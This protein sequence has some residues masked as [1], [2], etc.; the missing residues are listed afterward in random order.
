MNSGLAIA[1][2]TAVLKNLLEDGLVQNTALSSMGNI[3]VTTLPPDQISVGVDGQPQLNLFLYQVSQ[4]RNAD[5]I[6]HGAQE[7]NPDNFSRSAQANPLNETSRLAINLHY[8]ITVY[9]T[10]DFQTE[11]L[12]GCVMQLMHQSP[13]LSNDAIRSSLKHAA[14]MNRAGPFAQAVASNSFDVL[15]NQLGQV[16]IEPD[17]FD[18]EQ[19]S[20]LWSLLQ[21]SY[22]PS[23]TYQVSMVSISSEKSSNPM[24]MD[25]REEASNDREV[26]VIEKVIASPATN[27]AITPGCDL[28]LYGKHLDGD[29]TKVRLD[30]DELTPT[31][32]EDIR[33]LVKSSPT[34]QAGVH[35]I[36]VI[37]K[38]VTDPL[39]A[40]GISSN[41]ATFILRPRITASA[42]IP[43]SD[44]Q[45]QSEETTIAVQF[46][47]KISPQQQV[48]LK[49]ISVDEYSDKVYQIR[50]P[51]GD[52]ETDTVEIS[53]NDI[54]SGPYL[55]QAQVDGA[56]SLLDVDQSKNRVIIQTQNLASSNE[57]EEMNGME[58][59]VTALTGGDF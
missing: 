24:V 46:T 17:L 59:Q 8:L 55:V 40:S 34:L 48:Y 52:L 51:P 16:Q 15:I 7:T 39:S 21:G 27:G 26:P 1:S 6:G 11:M 53:V 47:P 3:L 20:K 18:T 50:T 41:A 28:I 44:S 30:G 31:V 14:S 43:N 38:E 12:L 4:N 36:Q 13:V 49:L 45:Q 23:V 42:K 2:I 35:Q 54:P 5:W 19:M 32:V 29:I 33:L 56:E 9:G 57:D 58:H 10:Q 22:R 25:S 37:H